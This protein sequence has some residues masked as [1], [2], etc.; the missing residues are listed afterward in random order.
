MSR[1]TTFSQA[2]VVC[3]EMEIPEEADSAL[4]DRFVRERDEAA[5]ETLVLRHGPRVL[6]ICRRWLGHGQDAEDAFQATFVVLVNRA[7]TIRDAESLDAWLCGVA[8]R[9][10]GRAK[11]RAGRRR[12]REGAGVDIHEVPATAESDLGDL[13]PLLQAEVDRLPEKYRR[14]IELCYWQGLTSEQAAHRLQCPTGTLKWRLSRAREILRSRLARLGLALVAFLMVRRPALATTS[15]SA[16]YSGPSSRLAYRLPRASADRL[17]ADL[18]RR[19]IELATLAR[20]SPFTFANALTW[21]DVYSSR[22]R[23]RRLALFGSI[24]ALL[25]AS[26]V[27]VLI[28][29]FSVPPKAEAL[30]EPLPVIPTGPYHSCH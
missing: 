28:G 9:V 3:R 10:A 14:P 16:S 15:G 23:R 11:L 7:G 29:F 8:R 30:P 27:Y 18:V 4:L 25:A 13:R 20:D 1:S 21:A 22:A 19:T 17:P 12:S 6:G 2:E 26:F 5:F 24:V